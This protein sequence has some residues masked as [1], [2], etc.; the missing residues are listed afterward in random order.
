MN[1]KNFFL[2]IVTVVVFFFIFFSFFLKK[3]FSFYVSKN[4]YVVS[5]AYNCC[6]EAQKN[7][8]KTA[9]EYGATKVFS[10][11]LDTLEAPDNVKK[12]IVEN[13][14]GSGYWIW[15]PYAMKQI[16]NKTNPG[17]IIIYCDASTFFIK[18]LN[19]IID[20]INKNSILCFLH[21][22]KHR[23]SAWTKINLV[24]YLGY[25]EDWCKNEE[26]AKV[27]FRG[28]FLGV[29]NDEI[30]NNI[31]DKWLQILKPE[32]SHLIDDTNDGEKNCKDF[33]ESR[34]DQQVLSMIL[35]KYV[36]HINFPEYHKQEYGFVAHENI[37]GKN[38]H[39]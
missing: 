23:Q 11:N 16:I 37:N 39:E 22:E 35:Y 6:T 8:E 33:K 30:G 17:D 3:R 12:Y 36:P 7:L 20:F 21:A 34:H 9:L 31:I 19:K 24:K 18:P 27:Q 13:K 10:L 2:I 4:I 29:K 25:T 38:R 28:C 1:K 5:F 26:G 32:N 15:K 14:R